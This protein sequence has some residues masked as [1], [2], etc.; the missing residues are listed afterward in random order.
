MKDGK[1]RGAR[2]LCARA[3]RKGVVILTLCAFLIV[4]PISKRSAIA[5]PPPT[6]PALR[7]EDLERM[8]LQNNPTIGQAEAAIRAAEG[9]RA[10]VDVW[11]NATQLEG[12][13]LTGALD[14]PGGTDDASRQ[15]SQ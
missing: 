7:L 15:D 11:R 6:E 2:F 4:A 8:A 9:R 14:A 10:L 13:M 5:S 3:T 1:P 12:F